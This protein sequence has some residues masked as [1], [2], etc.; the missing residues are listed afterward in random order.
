MNKLNITNILKENRL[1]NDEVKELI[2]YNNELFYFAINEPQ[3]NDSNRLIL[4]NNNH[5]DFRY[6]IMEKIGK[7]AFSNVYKCFDHK[8]DLEVAVKVIRDEERFLVGQ[9]NPKKYY[10]QVLLPR[11]ARLESWYSENRTFLIDVIVLF[12]TACVV[13]RPSSRLAETWVHNASEVE[14]ADFYD[15]TQIIDASKDR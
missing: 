8:R 2:S 7:G 11:K 6:Q 5:L 4:R 12:L 13:M 15:R 14:F 10:S 1:S 9:S 3:P